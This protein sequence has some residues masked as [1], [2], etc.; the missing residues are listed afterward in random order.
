MQNL[1]N[2]MSI[3]TFIEVVNKELLT[4]IRQGVDGVNEAMKRQPRVPRSTL[5]CM[6]TFLGKWRRKS[7]DAVNDIQ[8][9]PL[10]QYLKY[11]WKM[12]TPFFRRASSFMMF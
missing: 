1:L 9:H 8:M 11:D 10:Y 4:R 7:R 12:E 6:R 5:E 3:P 2:V